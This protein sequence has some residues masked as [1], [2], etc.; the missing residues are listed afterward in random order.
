MRRA[1]YETLIAAV[2][3]GRIAGMETLVL[4]SIPHGQFSYGRRAA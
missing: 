3:G 2:R 1:T 4:L